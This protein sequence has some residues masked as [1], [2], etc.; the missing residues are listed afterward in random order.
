MK[1]FWNLMLAMLVIMGA[2]SCSKDVDSVNVKAENGG[3]SFYAEIV[4]G[5][6]TRVDLEYD[7]V[8]KVWKS[9]WTGDDV[10]TLVDVN[11]NTFLF[12]NTPANPNKFTCTDEGVENIINEAVTLSIRP[13]NYSTLGK[14][15]IVAYHKVE[16]FNPEETI[17]IK[18]QNSFL[19]YNYEGAGVVTLTLTDDAGQFSDFFFANDTN[20][21]SISFDSH[22]GERWVSVS[23]SDPR[24][25]TLSY[26]IDGVKCKEASIVL[27]SG[28]VY[29][30][31]TLTLPYEASAYSVVGT[32]NNWTAGVTPMYLVG[33]YCVAYGVEFTAAEGNAF[34]V[35]GNDKWLGVDNYALGTWMSLA[36][37]AGDIY[38]AA[39]TYDIYYSEADNKLCVVA[40]GT[41]VPEM[42]VFSLGVIGLGGNWDTDIDMTLEDDY[43]TLKNVAITAT[44][45]FKIRAYDAWA[46]N[47][48]IASGETVETIAINADTM[49][50][51]VQDGKNMQVAAGTYDLYF[52]YATKEFYAMTA[53]ATPDD[54]EIPQYK[55]YVYQYNNTWNPLNLYTWDSGEVSHTGSWPGSATTATES[56]NGYEYKVWTMPRTATSKQMNLILNDG[57]AQTEDF[58]L[59][60]LDKDYYL[61]LNGTLISFIEDKDNPEPE[62]IEGEP[63][64]STWALAGNFNSWSDLVMYTTS[65]DNLFVAKSVAI[66]AYSS[67]KVKKVADWDINFGG[68]INYLN[69]NIWTTV[70]SGGSDLTIINADTYDIY[71]DNANKRIY[72]MKEGVD[73]TTATEQTTNGAAADL[74]GATWGL[75]GVHNDW[76]PNDTVLEWDGSIGMHVAKNAEITGEFK[77][78]TDNDWATNYGGKTITVDAT[79]GTVLIFNAGTNCKLSKT[80]TYDIY[81]DYSTSKIWVKTPGSAAPTK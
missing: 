43:Y 56:I 52:N 58:V 3:V 61:L 57:T 22:D 2:A 80:G 13:L 77:V 30:L 36:T 15:G 10:I 20:S 8:S 78:R 31:G 67:I 1:K 74:S 12:K 49:Y 4:N 37:S 48:G 27:Q 59:G 32:N 38:V 29:N 42:P 70:Y 68:G 11:D 28:K 54:L 33:D 44:D 21:T 64:P 45:T 40:A 73:Y 79:A 19:R 65:V 75:C 69:T 17:Q 72:V 47:Y 46:E 51:L 71:F 16:V 24:P 6:D 25:A 41:E 50:T 7:E 53:G 81:W 55:I 9:V 62:V 18:S 66:D 39:G 63:Q 34:K 26:S 23:A 60:T 35:L 5:D 76:S 14:K